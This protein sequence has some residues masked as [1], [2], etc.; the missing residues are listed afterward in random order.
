MFLFDRD[1]ICTYLLLISY[2]SYSILQSST[3]YR[4]RIVYLVMIFILW[5][6]IRTQTMR[7]VGDGAGTIV[8]LIVEVSL[9]MRVS[10]ISRIR[11]VPGIYLK[12][13]EEQHFYFKVKCR[14]TTTWCSVMKNVNLQLVSNVLSHQ[15]VTNIVI[16]YL[17]FF[18][19]SSMKSVL[20]VMSFWS[21][22]L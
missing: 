21:I 10:A 2:G 6:Q 20:I 13:K 16:Q 19:M 8:D 17:L 1:N 22:V 5:D 9:F 7:P 18:I 12:V 11:I 15:F 3:Y 4:T 14:E